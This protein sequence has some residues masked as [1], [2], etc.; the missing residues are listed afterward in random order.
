MILFIQFDSNEVSKHKNSSIVEF[1]FA[2]STKH[3]S[4]K[5]DVISAKL[6]LPSSLVSFGEMLT[7]W[8]HLIYPTISRKCSK[9]FNNKATIIQQFYLNINIMNRN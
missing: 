6:H 2:F 1:T 5:N 9:Q 4:M 3:C 7:Q 8:S